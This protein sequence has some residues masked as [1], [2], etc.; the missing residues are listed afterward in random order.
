MNIE[1]KVDSKYIEPKLV[2]YTNEITEDLKKIIENINTNQANN[3]QGYKEKKLYILDQKKIKTVYSENGKVYAEKDN[4]TYE[5]KNRIYEL[6]EMLDKKIF[7]RISNSEIVNFKNVEN[8]DFSFTGTI[9]L[10][11]KDGTNTFVSRRYIPKIKK[12]LKIGE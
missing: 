7:V 3:I 12:F 4:D 10:N 2:V 8:L 9:K 1:I 6:E 11:F 5:L